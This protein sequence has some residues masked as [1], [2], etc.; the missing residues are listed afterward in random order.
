MIQTAAGTQVSQAPTGVPISMAGIAA[1]A[2]G[3]SLTYTVDFGD[4]TAPVVETD[5][6]ATHTYTT[7]G[8]FD[9]EMTA[10]SSYGI[11]TDY[12]IGFDIS[13]AAAD[14]QLTVT[15]AGALSVSVDPANSTDPWGVYGYLIDFGDGSSSGSINE[16]TTSVT[17]TYATPGTYKITLTLQDAGNDNAQTTT[18][19]TTVGSD[20][21]AIVPTRILNTHA[22]VGTGGVIAKV[23]GGS[24]IN[25]KVGGTGSI[26]ANA[27]AVALNLTATDATSSGY[28]TAYSTGQ[29]KPGTSN[30]AYADGQVKAA[31]V[32]IGLGKGGEITLANTASTTSGVDLIADVA[33]YFT[34]SSAA[35]YQPIAPDRVLDTGTGVGETGG[36]AAKVPGDGTLAVK[37]NA[38]SGAKAVVMNLT[39]TDDPVGGVINAYPY[40]ES[41]PSTSS[42]NFAANSTIANT[43]VVPLGSN[44]EVDLYNYDSQPVDLIADVA[45]YFTSSATDAFVPVAPTRLYGGGQTATP[46]GAGGVL[47]IQ[48]SQ[49]DQALPTTAAAYVYNVTVTGPA[50]GG[51]LTAYGAGT[52]RP[53]PANVNFVPEQT[54]SNSAVSEA[55]DEGSDPGADSFYNGS[56]GT[57]QLSIDA[58]G[59]FASV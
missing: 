53:I 22:G 10:R 47:T 6:T 4:G 51:Y 5:G 48:P 18:S 1:S 13:S 26:P 32:I 55:G 42:L 41:Q 34:Q 7:A 43:V 27:T 54:A 28:I 25:L 52:T 8:D 40:G 31:G 36:K 56:G 50:D 17:H 57:V 46:L 23:A 14:P 24:S 21:T 39:V 37:V 49:Q 9:L 15:S 12:S 58:F 59:Y 45:G 33:G 38:P 3:G 29:T 20:F 11:E 16:G 30:L 19:Y 35:G 44:G 2:W